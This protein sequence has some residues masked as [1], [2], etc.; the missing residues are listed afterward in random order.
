MWPRIYN[1]DAFPSL[2]TSIGDNSVHTYLRYL[3][4]LFLCNHAQ[5]FKTQE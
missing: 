3:I 1:V 2:I 4:T 5:K